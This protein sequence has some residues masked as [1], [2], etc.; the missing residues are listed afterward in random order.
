MLGFVVVAL[1]ELVVA[2]LAGCVEEVVGGPVLV[3]EGLPDAVVVVHGDGVLDTQVADGFADVGLV[4]L[5]GELGRVD[6]DDDETGVF[7]LVVPG[8]DVGEG[9][10]TVDAG[11]GPEVDEDYFALKRC[12][13]SARG[14]LG[15][16]LYCQRV[17]PVSS[18]RVVGK[19]V[20]AAGYGD[21]LIEAWSGGLAA[22]EAI[23]ETLFE[24]GGAG[25]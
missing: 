25:Q 12:V 6:A 3:M 15:G 1:A 23:D 21:V 19:E 7:V 16:L 8:L 18:G 17:A 11:V 24:V 2:E 9:A 5:E 20:S 14:E 10:E 22:V 13:E 4:L